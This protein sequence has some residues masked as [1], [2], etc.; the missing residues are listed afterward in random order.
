MIYIN[1]EEGFWNGEQNIT[2]WDNWTPK[3]IIKI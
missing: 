2:L 1:N 3:Y